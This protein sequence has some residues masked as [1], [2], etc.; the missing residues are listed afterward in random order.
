MRLKI[1]ETGS[2][3]PRLN[4]T[5]K[6]MKKY[7]D[8]LTTTQATIFIIVAVIVAMLADNVF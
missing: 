5:L 3:V 4:Q 6:I 2:F 7:S 8:D 1:A